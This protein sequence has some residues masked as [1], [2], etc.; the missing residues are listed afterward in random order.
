MQYL[1]AVFAVFDLIVI[2]SKY[3]MK[4]LKNIEKFF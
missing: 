3:I 4:Q 2:L 1:I